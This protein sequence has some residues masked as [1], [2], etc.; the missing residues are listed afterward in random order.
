[1]RAPVIVAAGDI[2]RADAPGAPQRA[3][4]ALIGR[5]DP[6]AVLP[7]GDD[8]YEM[9]ELAQFQSSYAPTWGR[10]LGKTFPIPGNHEYLTSG[11][12][13]YFS[14]FG[15]RAHGASGWYAYNLGD[16]HL[17][18]LNSFQGQRPPAR[19]LTWLRR[20]L[21]RDRHR[22]QLA[23]FH[24]PRWSSSEDTPAMGAFW[25]LLQADGVDVVL[26]GHAHMYERFAP[27]LPDGS[28]NP[29]GIREFVVGTGGESLR[30]PI[31]SPSRGSR[32]RKAAY[33]VL[34]M[35]LLAGRFRFRFVRIGGSILDRGAAACH[36][37]T[38]N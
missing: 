27:L 24:H 23:Y 32:V 26:N 17:V 5:I 1:M 34:R 20:N 19:E 37:A 11:A 30:S 14:Y 6:R 25:R 16:W 22:C 3:T 36:G 38:G 8:Q 9:G 7:L 33:G 4:A 21:H 31:T 28:V 10:F 15:A 13:G 2:A 35:R 12:R 18:A 29:R